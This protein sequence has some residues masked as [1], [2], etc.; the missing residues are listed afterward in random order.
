MHNEYG[1]A[2]VPLDIKVSLLDSANF[3]LRHRALMFTASLY[4]GM[5]P[6]QHSTG[7]C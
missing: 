2:G 4:A 3:G 7:R 5:Y 1:V 6:D